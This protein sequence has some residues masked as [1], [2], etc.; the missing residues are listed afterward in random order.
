MMNALY[1]WLQEE[2]KVQ[3]LTDYIYWFELNMTQNSQR[4]M[5][6]IAE[7]VKMQTQI[8]P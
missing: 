8:D 7:A 5:D 6:Q 4:V 3:D 1:S 2:V